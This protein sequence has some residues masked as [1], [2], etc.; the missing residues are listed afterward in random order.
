MLENTFFFFSKYE[1][2][3]LFELIQLILFSSFSFDKILDAFTKEIQV[4]L[5]R[6]LF[7]YYMKIFRLSNF[8]IVF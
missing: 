3:D 8:L 6:R 1:E 4:I 7:Y 5:S 2:S